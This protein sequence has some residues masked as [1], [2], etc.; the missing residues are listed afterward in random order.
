LLFFSHVCNVQHRV[1]SSKFFL[2][3]DR[4]TGLVCVAKT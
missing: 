2:K 4:R 3:P 1:L